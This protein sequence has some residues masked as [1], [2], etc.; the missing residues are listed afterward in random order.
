MLNGSLKG[1]FHRIILLLGIGGRDSIT[2]E[3]AIYN[4]YIS[5][6]YCLLGDYMRLLQEP[7]KSVQTSCPCWDGQQNMIQMWQVVWIF[8]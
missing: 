4:W 3:K 8:N 1:K 2:P 6:I 7:P 5:G